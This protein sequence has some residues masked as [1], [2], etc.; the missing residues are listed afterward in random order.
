MGSPATSFAPLIQRCYEVLCQ[1]VGAARLLT[2]QQRFRNRLFEG[3]TPGSQY[4]T[5]I[6]SPNRKLCAVVV[7]SYANG[8][9]QEFSD[10]AHYDCELRVDL[11][12]PVDDVAQRSAGGLATLDLISLAMASAADD[13]HLVR[14]ALSWPP[15]MLVTIDGLDTGLPGGGG[16]QFKSFGPVRHDPGAQLVT[17]SVLFAAVVFL[18]FPT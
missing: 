17:A 15:N 9:T 14:A 5:G 10:R 13:A 8:N 1:G 6:R 2:E 12:Y 16:I 4:M 3:Q 18:R 11:S 7:Q